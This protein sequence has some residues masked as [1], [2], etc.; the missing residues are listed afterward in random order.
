MALRFTPSEVA[1]LRELSEA[2]GQTMTN[3]IRMAIR[4]EYAEKLGAVPAVTAKKKR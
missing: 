3:V 2:T 4:R 1:M